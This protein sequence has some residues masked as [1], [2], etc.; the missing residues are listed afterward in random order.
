MGAKWTW[1]EWNVVKMHGVYGMVACLLIIPFL[2]YS[3]REFR[4]LRG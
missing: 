2:I 3:F 4:A 1:T